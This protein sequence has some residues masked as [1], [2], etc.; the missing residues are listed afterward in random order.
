[1]THPTQFPDLN[2]TENLWHAIKM[3]LQSENDVIKMRLMN[4]VCKVWRSLSILY[5]CN[6]IGIR[7]TSNTVTQCI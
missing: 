5:I 3:K 7:S 1:M 4:A 6:I 2:K